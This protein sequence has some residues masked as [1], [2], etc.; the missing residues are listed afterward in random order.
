[1]KNFRV[2][3][4]LL[5][6]T[7]PAIAQTWD[8]T[9]NK[10]LNGTYYFREVTITASDAFA[11]YG[12]ITFTNGTYSMGSNTVYFQGST[13]EINSFPANGSYSIA[14]SGLGFI[15]NP[16]PLVGSPIYGLV[17]ANGVFVGSVT[18]TAVSDIFIAAPLASQN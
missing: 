2:G 6:A 16:N 14:A 13:G 4:V 1:M 8:N 11:A 5:A 10:L 12:T 18:E 9:G 7:F 17:G 15:N 3:L